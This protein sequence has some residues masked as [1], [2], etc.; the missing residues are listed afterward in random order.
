MDLFGL[1][2]VLAEALTGAPFADRAPLPPTALSDLVRRL[3]ADDPTQRGKPS[4]ALLDLAAACDECPWPRWASRMLQADARCRSADPHHD[5][6]H[7]HERDN[8]PAD[9]ER[10]YPHR[11]S[12]SC[13]PHLSISS[14]S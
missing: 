2:A 11:S 6:P 1:G 8:D 3:L 5:Q 10:D 9:E 13:H 7:Q 14:G 12:G 4:Q